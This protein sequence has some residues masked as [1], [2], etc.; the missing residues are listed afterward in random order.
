MNLSED[1]KQELLKIARL[2]ILSNFYPS[3]P[4]EDEPTGLTIKAGA[5]V[6][7]H[8]NGQLRGCIGRMTSDL[9]L[10]KTIE[11]MAKEAAFHDPRFSPLREE[12]MPNIDI[13]ISV[14]SPFFNISYEDIEIG[15][16]GLMLKHGY[17]TGVF[18][19][20]VPVEQRWNKEEYIVNLYQKAGVP[21]TETVQKEAELFG[22]T[23]IVFGE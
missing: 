12:E 10:Y 22:F 17:R 6:T 21:Y 2:S 16:H 4:S 13:E 15:K 1:N 23:A 11:L 14:L 19:P 7:I 3:Q 9:P 8:K 20:Q 18:L 5:F